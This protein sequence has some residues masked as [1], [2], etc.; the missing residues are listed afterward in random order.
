MN[1]TNNVPE[2][3]GE[4]R[5]EINYIIGLFEEIIENSNVD[6][7]IALK[8]YINERLDEIMEMNTSSD[9]S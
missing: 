2:I 3:L 9:E 7:Q 4:H 1:N 8:K 5:T 6:A